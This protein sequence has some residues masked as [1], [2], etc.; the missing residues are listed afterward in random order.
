M[1]QLFFLKDKE[2]LI[3]VMKTF[4]IFLSFSALKPGKS[5]C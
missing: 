4:D 3:G 1:T 2:S 5:K